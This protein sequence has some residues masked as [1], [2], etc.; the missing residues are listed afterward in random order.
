MKKA[1]LIFTAIA[2]LPER[3]YLHNLRSRPEAN[4]PP[5]RRC[6]KGRTERKYCLSG[7]SERG[8]HSP[9]VALRL[10]YGYENQ[11]LAGY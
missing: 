10:T 11:A 6:L 1:I 5:A 8:C 3:Q 7:K 2:L 9:Q 4:E